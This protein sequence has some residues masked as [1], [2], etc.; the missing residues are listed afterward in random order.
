MESSQSQALERRYDVASEP[1]HPAKEAVLI[2][3][4]Q[5][6]L[7]VSA[8]RRIISRLYCYLRTGKKVRNKDIGDVYPTFD[9]THSHKIFGSKIWKK[10]HLENRDVCGRRC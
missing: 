8:I 6:S 5:L 9:I 3:T 4:G 10:N 2:P 1:R 7:S